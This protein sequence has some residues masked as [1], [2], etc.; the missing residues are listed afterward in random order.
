MATVRKYERDGVVVNLPIG[1][2]WTTL[3]FGAFP[4]LFRGDVKW[5]AVQIVAHILMFLGT[6]W[7][8]LWFG[9][10]VLWFVFA[11][12]Y[13]GRHEKDHL[14]QGFKPAHGAP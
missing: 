9:N 7:W 5:A 13:N 3:L 1:F 4:A 2:S 8:T 10:V 11:A 12:I 6:A 14:M